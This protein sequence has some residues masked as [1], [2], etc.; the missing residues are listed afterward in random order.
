M[1]SRA[2]SR[3]KSTALKVSELKFKK[4]GC[5]Q[6]YLCPFHFFSTL[7]LNLHVF[8]FHELPPMLTLLLFSAKKYRNT[9]TKWSHH[10]NN[11][12]Y[13]VM[14]LKNSIVS[15]KTFIYLNGLNFKTTFEGLIHT[16]QA[17]PLSFLAIWILGYPSL[18]YCRYANSHQGKVF[19][20]WFEYIIRLD[21]I[22]DIK[23]KS[24]SVLFQNN[25]TIYNYFL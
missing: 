5:I 20:V 2:S 1:S 12:Y 6:D 11:T 25:Q 19:L 23:S 17:M 14:S 10:M 22:W 24:I 7:L 15:I 18:N 4:I 8:F 16:L 3:I 13:I 21:P 9:L